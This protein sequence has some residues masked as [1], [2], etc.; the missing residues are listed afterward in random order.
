MVPKAS[1]ARFDADPVFKER[2][3]Q[4]VVRLQ[5]GD[6]A[7]RAIWNLLCDISRAEFQKVCAIPCEGEYN[8]FLLYGMFLTMRSY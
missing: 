5:G 2:A 3:R 7:C 4:N 1:K 8:R 6:A